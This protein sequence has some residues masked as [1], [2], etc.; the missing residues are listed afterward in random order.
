MEDI[1]NIQQRIDSVINKIKKSDLLESNKD[2]LL[3]FTDH[4]LA[5]GVGKNK[6]SRYLYDLYNISSWLN[7]KFEKTTK[8][9]VEKLM[10]KLQETKYSEWTKKGYKIIIKKFYKWL[11]NSKEYPEEVEWIKSSMKEN[12]KKLPEEILNEEEIKRLIEHASCVRDKALLSV[13]YDSGCRI[14]E[15]LNLRIKDIESV[16]YGMRI[17]L[18]GKT[19]M[20]KVL[21]I[22]SVP[23]L[24]EWLNNHPNKNP[25]SN[26]WIKNNGKRLGYGRIR[27][28]LKDIAKR[29]KINKKVNPHNFRHS[30]ATYYASR[31][32]ERE[33]MEYFGWR[34][35]DTVGI[36]VH[37]NGETVD[38]A[39]LRSQG[40][41][42]EDEKEGILLKSKKCLRC[43]KIN[44]PTDKFC[45]M[46]SM[47]LDEETAK[48]IKQKDMERQQA[49]EIMNKLVNDPEI[50]QL[51]KEKININ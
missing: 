29:A 49:D 25:S 50:L 30:R 5:N 2:K 31:L 17:Y 38:N 6:V 26:V 40:I 51:I 1:Y 48:E 24:S 41:I 43:N 12:H 36:Y 8:Q 28:L 46:C 20:R 42:K 22:F 15:L 7:K 10:V 35:S 45:S 27:N 19:G 3:E 16:E 13:L 34:K 39:I 37:L 23:Y 4:C 14:G 47:P 21:L 32:R 9:D 11:R 44:K 33:M 18:T